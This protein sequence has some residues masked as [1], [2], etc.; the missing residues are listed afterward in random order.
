MHIANVGGAEADGGVGCGW[1]LHP[2]EQLP[3]ASSARESR[4]A[5]TSSRAAMLRSARAGGI[6]G[7]A[8]LAIREGAFPPFLPT[9]SQK[10]AALH[11]VNLS[12]EAV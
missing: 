10:S 9:A 11:E 1:K 8:A 6:P 7:L 4:G 12:W 5:S 3:Q 2:V